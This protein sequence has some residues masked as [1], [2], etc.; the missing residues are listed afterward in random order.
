MAYYSLVASSTLFLG[1]VVYGFYRGHRALPSVSLL[2]MST[3]VVFW[4]DPQS[5]EKRALDI[6]VSKSLG[7]LYFVYG[8]K[9][10]EPPSMRMYGYVNIIG[11]L[12]SYQMAYSLYPGP[13]W[14]PCHMIFH[15]MST[16]GQLMILHFTSG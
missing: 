3:S 6:M 8:W 12:T 1:P 7:V 16:L 13:Y 11:I 14:I 4:L 5:K 9:Y 10:I 15:Y 2:A